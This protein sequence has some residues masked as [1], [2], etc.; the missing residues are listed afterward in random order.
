MKLLLMVGLLM[1]SLPL[2][3]WAAPLVLDFRHV[4]YD[5]QG[6][7]SVTASHAGAPRHTFTAAGPST[8]LYWDAQDGVG[9]TGPSYSDDEVEGND[10]VLRLTFEAPV[11]IIGIGISDLFFER[12]F[13]KTPHYRE[14]GQYSYNEG[15]SW[16]DFEAP[17]D[18]LRD[19]TNG[20]YQFSTFIWT[21][22]LLFRAPGFISPNGY[23]QLHDFSVM[24]LTL[25]PT[26]PE[27]VPEPSTLVLLGLGL[28]GLSK[29]F[30]RRAA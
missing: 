22:T 16:L 7:S 21:S 28:I 20:E 14:R 8:S 10:E 1:L 15:L 17:L 5:A 24:S 19:V 11:R 9:V 29:K 23:G 27:P 26:Q 25:K 12:E 13:P 30:Q 2:T 18:N 3:G 4:A 6:A